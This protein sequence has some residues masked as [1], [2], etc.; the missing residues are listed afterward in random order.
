MW[1]AHRGQGEEE[2]KAEEVHGVKRVKGLVRCVEVLELDPEHNQESPK[3]FK[4]CDEM[5][6]F[7]F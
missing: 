6:R 2:R 7:A 3:G 1:L 5:G 4:A